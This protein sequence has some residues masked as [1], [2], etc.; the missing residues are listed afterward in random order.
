MRR[1]RVVWDSEHGRIGREKGREPTPP[2]GDGI[3]RVRRETGGRGGKTVT[4]IQGIPARS[5]S[6]L[7][8]IAK[9]LKQHC[10]VGGALKD[11]VIE[12][13][14]DQRDKVMAFL[15]A[16]EIPAKLAGG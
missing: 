12:L 9:K 2:A 1:N 10:G 16:R 11:F 7:K 14:G 6:E 15:A 8:D 3:A 13:Q 5:V 4:T